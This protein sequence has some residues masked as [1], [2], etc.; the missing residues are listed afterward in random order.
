MSGEPRIS[1]DG[2]SYWDGARWIPM[3][4]G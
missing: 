3:S 1:E 2:K 4:H